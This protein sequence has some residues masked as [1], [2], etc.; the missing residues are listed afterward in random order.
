MFGGVQVACRGSGLGGR[1]WI[2]GGGPGSR[3]RGVVGSDAH[4][5]H[6]AP[7]RPQGGWRMGVR[8]EEGRRAGT[9]QGSGLVPAAG[10]GAGAGA[11]DAAAVSPLCG[12]EAAE[13]FAASLKY[14]GQGLVAA[15]VQ[16]A[17]TGDCLMQAFADRQ[18]VVDTL[19]KG[20]ATFWS[21]SRNAPWTK[22]ETSGHFMEVLSVHVDCDGDS[23][24][25]LSVPRGPAC[26]TNEPTC[27]FREAPQLLSP[28]EG[29]T[30]PHSPLSR[31]LTTAFELEA[32]IRQRIREDPPAGAKPSWTQRLA[33][34][35]KLL[36]KKVREEAGE[37]CDALEQGEGA[38]AVASE[39]AD[40][41][42]H[43]MVLLQVADVDAKDVLAVLR[44][45]AGTSGVAEK[46]ARTTKGKN[47]AQ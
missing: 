23:L 41:L 25:Y 35:P 3:R 19:T 44:R 18:A 26:H 15:I 24:V 40:L 30:P 29:G 6:G 42:Y 37:L 32:T 27:W 22:G 17:D 8:R 10:A 14:D 31:P 36:C 45:R 13:S 4:G 20:M 2:R 47:S 11:G 9:G 7:R 43:A 5:A 12:V 16:D 21:R 38:E 34:D 28:G 1:R 46:A 33:A 39:A